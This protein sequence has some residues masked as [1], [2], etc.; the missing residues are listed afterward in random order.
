MV[1]SKLVVSGLVLTDIDRALFSLRTV[2]RKLASRR[3]LS[4][5]SSPA[6]GIPRTAHFLLTS[7]LR[8]KRSHGGPSEVLLSTML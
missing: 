2:L 1:F 5:S 6:G 8:P 7:F 4:P 3:V